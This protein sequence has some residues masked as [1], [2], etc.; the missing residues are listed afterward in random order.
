V[1]S[2]G[3][4]W[5]DNFISNEGYQPWLPTRIIETRYFPEIAEAI[6]EAGLVLA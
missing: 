5:A 2:A 3:H 1:S 4:E 6:V